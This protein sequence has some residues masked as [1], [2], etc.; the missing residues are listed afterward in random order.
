MKIL[1]VSDQ[2][3]PATGGI[4]QYL[5]GLVS[6]LSSRHHL[7]VLTA[8]YPGFQEIEIEN[9]N[10]VYRSEALSGAIPDPFQ[11][12]SRWR[13]LLP[14]IEKITPD[15]IYAN[16]H[17]SL[18]TIKA[19]K[20]LNIPIV[21]GCHGW[22]LLCPLRIR[23]LRPDGSLCMNEKSFASCLRC[24]RLLRR[25]DRHRSEWIR[26]MASLKDRIIIARK[27]AQYEEA[28]RLIDDASAR[29]CNSKLTASL[30]KSPQTYAIH[31]GIDGNE[32]VRDDPEPFRKKYALYN[33]YLFLPGRLN[34][35]KGHEWA[36]RAMKALPRDWSLVIAGGPLTI[37]NSETAYVANLKRLAQKYGVADRML[38]VG[39][40]RKPDLL[41]AY[42]GAVAT[43]VPS[44]WLESF[45][46]VAAESMACGT[47]VIATSSCGS[48]EIITDGYD[49]VVVPRMDANAIA[50]AALNIA[51]QGSL[52]GGRARISVLNSIAW[53]VIAPRVERVLSMAA[54]KHVAEQQH[55]IA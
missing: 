23:L 1:I 12:M 26:A 40:L 4:E 43:I 31:L 32:F 29:I 14:I 53:T 17:T 30:F 18:A 46:Y 15:I 55:A 34:H 33:P 51:E 11:V 2:W 44:V 41:Q 16:H 9:G 19:A 42:S 50:V 45:G 6:H 54:G 28:G 38:F 25:G 20:E 13:L 35:T 3:K 5:N 52:M 48:S 7:A 47:P 8:E 37:N 10:E 36:I 49:G 39:E 22:G 24:R 21:Y 27:V